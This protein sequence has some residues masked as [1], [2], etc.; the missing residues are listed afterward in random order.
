MSLNYL[1]FFSL[2]FV[3]NACAQT[4]Q[5]FII[6]LD[7]A[8]DTQTPGR[9]INTVYERGVTLH[10]VQAL[11]TALETAIPNV[12]VAI[13]RSP[14][15]T[16]APLHTANFSNRLCANLFLSF[17]FYHEQETKPHLFLYTFTCQQTTIIPKQSL[18]MLAYDQAY[19]VHRV[20]STSFAEQS[21]QILSQSLYAALFDVHGVYTL[22]CKPLMGVLAPAIMFDI[23]IAHADDWYL[24][25]DP[26]VH[27]ITHLATTYTP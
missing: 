8:G 26:I 12:V 4:Y 6:I 22:P 11:K 15:E 5:P 9:L 2:F 20:L 24:F 3:N 17:H 18:Q 25:I 21:K 14:G 13:T 1:I 7:P 10:Y 27:F 16:I 23:G 19:L